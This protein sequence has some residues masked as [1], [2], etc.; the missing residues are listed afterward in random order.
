VVDADLAKVIRPDVLPAITYLSPTIY[1]H[2]FG[3][4]AAFYGIAAVL[5]GYLILCSSYLP[6]ALGVILIIGG[7][8][9]VAENFFILLLPQYQPSYIILP[10]MLAM[11]R[12]ALGCWRRR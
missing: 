1:G 11:V 3:I 9:F 4:F 10:M 2:V 7:V 8:S 5:R 12:M 6:C